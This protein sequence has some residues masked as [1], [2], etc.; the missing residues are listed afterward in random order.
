MS[1]CHAI[2]NKTFL[3]LINNLHSN[4]RSKLCPC[5]Y[6]KNKDKYTTQLVFSS[7]LGIYIHSDWS[8]LTCAFQSIW[9]F[10]RKQ[11]PSKYQ[12]KHFEQ[13]KNSQLSTQACTIQAVLC[14]VIISLNGN[15]CGNQEQYIVGSFFF[16]RKRC[17]T[18]AK[19]QRKNNRS[20]KWTRTH[21]NAFSA[22]WKMIQNRHVGSNRKFFFFFHFQQQHQ[23]TDWFDSLLFFFS[24]VVIP[25]H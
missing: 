24:M 20:K 17:Y 10:N 19:N 14:L 8:L 6:S 9:S 2:P 25:G 11:K 3:Q 18:L 23:Q 12:L 7:W 4:D 15:L 1:T 13:K 16:Q 22:S 5:I 21:T